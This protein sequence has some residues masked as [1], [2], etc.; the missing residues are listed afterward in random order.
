MFNVFILTAGVWVLDGTGP[1]RSSRKALMDSYQGSHGQSRCGTVK[2]R[3]A[4]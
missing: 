4:K 2:I 1:Q 3:Q